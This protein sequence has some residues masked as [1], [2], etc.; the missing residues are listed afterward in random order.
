MAFTIPNI[1][2]AFNVN[3]AEVDSV[4]L[5]IL[6]GGLDG[7]A[8]VSGCA[9]T[10]QG[11]PNMTVAVASGVVIVAGTRASVVGAN[12][13]IT[14][15][16]GTNPRFDLIV[17]N[18]SAVLSAVAGTAAANPVFP[19]I[20][21]S[22]VVLAAVY[23]PASDTTIETNQITDKRVIVGDLIT[24]GLANTNSWTAVQT[25]T[26]PIL[27]T[28]A[29]GTPASGVMTSVS[30]TAAS[31]TAGNVTT[32]A[33]L[34]G[35][36][37][38]TGNAAILGSFTS[39]QLATALSNE[40][41]S[42]AAVFATD[43]TL[44]TPILG[45][46]QSGVMTNV[47]GTAASLTAGT[48][49]TNADLTGPVTSVGNATAIANKAL[50]I[51]KLADG[52]DGELIT[53]DASGVI[54]AVAAGNATQV[55]TSNGAGTAPTFQAVAAGSDTTYTHTWQDSSDN[56]ILRLTAGGS[57]SGNDDLTI[58]AGSNITLTPS[59]DNLT[60]AAASGSS[61]ID[62]SGTPADSHLAVWTDADTLEGTAALTFDG[63]KL[64]VLVASS[65]STLKHRVSYNA[66]IYMGLSQS[67]IDVVGGNSF[68]LYVNGSQKIEVGTGGDLDLKNGNV[69]IGTAGKGIDFSAQTATTATNAAADSGNGEV[70]DHYERGTFTPTLQH[71]VDSTISDQTYDARNGFY[72]R[73]GDMVQFSLS[74]D[75]GALGSLTTSNQC[76]I[77][78]LPFVNTGGIGGIYVSG[79]GY[80]LAINDGDCI[81]GRGIENTDAMRMGK[82]GTTSATEIM[83]VSNW[84]A[85]GELVVSGAYNTNLGQQ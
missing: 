45:T 81:Y 7:D 53:W 18:N 58:V 56:A 64:D 24:P 33:D 52:T 38:S 68:H 20:P 79:G 14:A 4:D 32:N 39:A 49:T 29:L 51:A 5:T 47:S 43:P 19:A 80:S 30:G 60:I 37:T 48:V 65:E 13:T 44:V 54:A 2:D 34:T 36:V 35:H 84:S 42:G 6:I 61:A 85:G 23:V 78:G 59:G 83:L 70:L 3:Q 16:N 8:V 22:S 77:R 17:S 21:A 69:I 27:I 1:D 41:G 71:A 82:W 50:A 63:T 55:L 11:S 74:L 46:P 10:A 73:I 40:T 15:A 67:R 28:P 31:L 72:T 66:S 76:F 75:M 12:V 62:V 57:G 25:L 9:V 26:S